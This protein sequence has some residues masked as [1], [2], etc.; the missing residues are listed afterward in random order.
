[1][2]KHFV[3]NLGQASDVELDER[4]GIQ[5][6][7][8]LSSGLAGVLSVGGEEDMKDKL[9]ASSVDD[10]EGGIT[11]KGI[12]ILPSCA[13]KVLWCWWCRHEIASGSRVLGCPVREEASVKSVGHRSLKTG[14]V[15]Y[16][17]EE[18]LSKAEYVTEGQFCGYA[19]CMAWIQDGRGHRKSE[20]IL[21]RMYRTE[22]GEDKRPPV[23]G[24]WKLLKAFGGHLERS[25]LND[26][27]WKILGMT[28]GFLTTPLR[29]VVDEDDDEE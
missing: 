16:T 22:T 28:P 3:L 10:V 27:S 8:L 14:G 26:T 9:M 25:E 20:E 2:E 24:H 19:C 7:T 17:R 1:M 5:A 18:D 23:C 6:D 21:V 4:Y 29:L 13:E 15:F 12:A 11:R